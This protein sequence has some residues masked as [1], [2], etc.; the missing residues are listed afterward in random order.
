MTHRS[1]PRLRA[2]AV[3]AV[4]PLALAVTACG[5]DDVTSED[6]AAADQPATAGPDGR[7]GPGGGFPGA[8]GEIAAVDRSTF[9]LQ[10]Q[11]T[12][13]VA[14]TVTGDTE[15]T[16]TVA[17]G[18]EDIAI[19]ACV[20]VGTEQAVEEGAT[21][22]AATV[23]VSEKDGGAGCGGGDVG[24]RSNGNG[25]RPEGERSERPEGAP[26]DRP[27]RGAR[28]PV[29]EVTAVEDGS[30]TVAV[31]AGDATEV[32]VAATAD[33]SYTTEVTAGTA[34]LRVG[35]CATATGETDDVGA[36]TADVVRVSD[37]VS[38]ECSV[39]GGRPGGRA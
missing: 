4:L 27:D 12:G 20:V 38:G 6:A 30:F 32:T 16:E 36:V 9:Q 17:G 1:T 14:V 18:F 19:G 13:Q 10:N 28:G 31:V 7:G 15:V 34:A 24:A 3:A 8:S 23:G 11:R 5:G 35:R 37:P 22:V 33:T 21:V 39:G 25:E 2:T 29:G 26:G